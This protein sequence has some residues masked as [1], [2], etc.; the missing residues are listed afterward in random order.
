MLGVVPMAG[1]GNCLFHALA[2]LDHRDGHALRHEVAE[3]ME[4][5]AC[6]QTGFEGAWLD[7]AEELH[8]GTW[9]G[10]TAITA[11]SL[12][13]QVRVE[14]HTRKPNDIVEVMDASHESVGGNVQ[15]PVRRILY[16]NQNHYDALVELEGGPH[17]RTPAWKQQPPLIYFKE[18]T[19][20]SSTTEAFPPLGS[21]AAAE[22]SKKPARFT[23]PRPGSKQAQKRKVKQQQQQATQSPDAKQTAVP[24]PP[25]PHPVPRRLRGKQ[26]PPPE[27]QDDILTELA[28]A[29]V[30]H[31]SAHPHRQHEDLIKDRP[32]KRIVCWGLQ[33]I[34]MRC[35][36]W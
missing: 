6:H 12:M 35:L 28:K 26:P 2:Y 30:R 14:V 1:D 20:P 7:E 15:L 36:V 17:G 19:G 5:E 29:P 34:K 9:G 13:K 8:Q 10:H 11:Y 22:K 24:P 3:F 33:T 18:G 16:I 23:Q 21:G 31:K 25:Q 4:T 27:M 32:N